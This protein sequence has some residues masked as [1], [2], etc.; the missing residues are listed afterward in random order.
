MDLVFRNPWGEK[1]SK[2]NRL[3]EGCLL[4]NQPVSY[5]ML[6]NWLASNGLFYVAHIDCSHGLFSIQT[7]G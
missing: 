6:T 3:K 7:S 5:Q 4:L 1:Q 2:A